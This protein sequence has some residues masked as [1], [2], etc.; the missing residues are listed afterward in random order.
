[1]TELKLGLYKHYKGKRCEVIGFAKHSESLEDLVVYK[2]LCDS[3]EFGSNPLWVR[4][5]GMFFESVDIDGVKTPR[6]KFIK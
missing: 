4:P 6:F 3:E 1:M 5:R 2:E